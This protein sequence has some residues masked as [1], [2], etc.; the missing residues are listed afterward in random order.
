MAPLTKSDLIQIF[1]DYGVVSKK[2][3]PNL[4]QD[5]GVFSKKDMPNLLKDYGVTTKKDLTKLERSLS[6]KITKSKNDLANRIANVAVAKAERNKVEKLENRL[7]TL[8]NFQ[9]S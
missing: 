6:L 8:E 9:F 4:L 3:M 1:K 2:D 5:Y 7:T